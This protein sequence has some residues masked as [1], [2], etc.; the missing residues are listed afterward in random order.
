MLCDRVSQEVKWFFHNKHWQNSSHIKVQ[1]KVLLK[2][3]IMWKSEG[4]GVIRKQPI[5]A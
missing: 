2:E 1:W 3:L 4:N 5:I